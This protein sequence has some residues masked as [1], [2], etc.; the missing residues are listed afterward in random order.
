MPRDC[1]GGGG[2]GSR[3]GQRESALSNI[4][5]EDQKALTDWEE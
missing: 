4:S 1:R 3:E 5:K 2:G